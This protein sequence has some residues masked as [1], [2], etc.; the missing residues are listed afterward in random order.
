[1]FCFSPDC[2]NLL[3]SEWKDEPRKLLIWIWF[4][5]CVRQSK[6][7]PNKCLLC[8]CVSVIGNFVQFGTFCPLFMKLFYAKVVWIFLLIPFE[9]IFSVFNI[10]FSFV[11]LLL[12]RISQY[13]NSK[14]STREIFARSI[15]C[16]R[17]MLFFE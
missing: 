2:W 7:Q 16:G 12:D 14:Y 6:R 8:M 4:F 5:D 17:L 3:W 9:Y 11:H 15:R 1:M 13:I 10:F